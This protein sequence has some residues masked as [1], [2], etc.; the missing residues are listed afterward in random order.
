M[1]VVSK[2]F[3]SVIYEVQ[4]DNDLVKLIPVQL[5]GGCHDSSLSIKDLPIKTIKRKSYQRNYKILDENQITSMRYNRSNKPKTKPFVPN[6]FFLRQSMITS[7]MQCPDKFY[8]IYE[9]NY[10]ESS[11]Y[12]QIGTAIHGVMEDYYENGGNTDIAELFKKWWIAHGPNEPELYEEWRGLLISYFEKL[13]D[14][15][16]PNI[17]ARELEFKTKI[18]SIPFSGTIDRI[19][20]IDENTILLID[21]KTNLQPYSMSELKNSI[22]FKS[23]VLALMTDELHKI[24]GEYDNIICAYELVRTGY[25]QYITYTEEE[26]TIFKEWLEIIWASILSGKDRNPKI[27][28]Y[29]GYC[30]KRYRCQAYNDM[31]KSPTPVINTDK[32]NLSVVAEELN[33]LKESAKIIKGRISELE[34]IIKNEIIKN[35]GPIQINNTTWSMT[36]QKTT[37]YP[38]DGIIDII[39]EDDQVMKELIRSLPPISSTAIKKIKAI[40]DYMDQIETIA[41]TAYKSPSLK[42]DINEENKEEE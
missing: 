5:I 38:V 26:L 40:K 4:E 29:C 18:G 28:Q 31:L 36:S 2:K 24:L 16:K 12:T 6:P 1:K 11:I 15:P 41:E 25:R 35:G 32:T 8:D 13:K 34:T 27:N 30:Q 23:Y 17:I 33:K 10:S 3:P 21:Y 42:Q 19:D 20:R 7:Y 14:K 9:N 37:L 22:Q 39:K